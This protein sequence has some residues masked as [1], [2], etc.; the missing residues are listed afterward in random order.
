MTT[1][2]SELI[3]LLERLFAH[4]PPRIRA[5]HLPPASAAGSRSGEF[6]ALELDN[7]ALGLSFVLLDGTLMKLIA[8]TNANPDGHG[9]A[10]ADALSVARW[11]GSESGVRRTLGFAAINALSRAFFDRAGYRPDSSTDSIGM[12][13]PQ[14]GEHIGMIGFFPPLVDR[15]VAAGARLTVAELNPEL[16]GDADGYRVTLDAGELADCVKVLSTSTVLLNDSLDRMLA[17]CCQ[18]KVFA[19]VGPGAGCLPDP[20]FARGVSLLGG[21]WI[22]DGPAFIAALRSGESWSAH[23]RKFAIAAADYPGVESLLA[24]VR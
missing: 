11:Y 6:C 3:A 23:S 16:A 24:G 14:P 18:A 5:L 13:E 9:L 21:S 15:I 20:L 12:L 8:E 1:I 4:Q 2:A 7:G 10:G 17:S 19:M 22:S